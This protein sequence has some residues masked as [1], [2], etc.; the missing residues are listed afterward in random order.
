MHISIILN[1]I[2]LKGGASLDT[3]G[4]YDGSSIV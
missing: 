1:G 2:I 4:S 3:A